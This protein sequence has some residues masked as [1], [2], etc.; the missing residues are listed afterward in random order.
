MS[1]LGQKQTWAALFDKPAAEHVK[2]N[3]IIN[4]ANR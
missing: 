2:I 4:A 1:A 3:R